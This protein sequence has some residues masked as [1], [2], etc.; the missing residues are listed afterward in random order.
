MVFV[1]KNGKQDTMKWASIEV[2]ISSKIE[3]K[4]TAPTGPQSEHR[5][6]VGKFNKSESNAQTFY[7]CTIIHCMTRCIRYM[8]S[9]M[10]EEY[11]VKKGLTPNKSFRKT[12]EEKKGKS[13]QIEVSK[14]FKS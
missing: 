1:S 7:S 10:K 5:R 6:E 13:K 14:N 12:F 11:K 2:E 8:F 3:E 4:K 9:Y